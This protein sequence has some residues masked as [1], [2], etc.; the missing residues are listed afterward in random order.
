MIRGAVFDMDGTLLDSNPY[1]NLAPGAWLS[2]LGK[3]AKPDLAQT[4]FAMTLPEAADYIIA[5]YALS[6][7]PQAVID[8]I[9]EAMERFYRKDV[10]FKS[11]V[12]ELLHALRARGVPCAVASVT[13]RHLVEAVLRRFDLLDCFAA[14]VT[15]S[16][17]GVGKQEPDVYLRAAELLGSTPPETLV[18]EDALHALR[19][20]RRAGFRTVGV[21]DDASAQVQAQLRALSDIYLPDFSDCSAVLTAE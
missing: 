8:G 16:D 18:F 11:G 9:N 19:T 1:W 14:L 6:C 13:D 5:E 4:I 7:T 10:P 17:V 2:T 3:Q 20:A 21:Y 15:T 12:P